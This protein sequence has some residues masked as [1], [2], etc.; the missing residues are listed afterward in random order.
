MAELGCLQAPTL[1][2]LAS[3]AGWGLVR[4]GQRTRHHR[5]GPPEPTLHLEANRWQEGPRHGYTQGLATS[6]LQ[7]GGSLAAVGAGVTAATEDL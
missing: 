2:S 4:P 1:T 7:L 3:P 6:D 5:G